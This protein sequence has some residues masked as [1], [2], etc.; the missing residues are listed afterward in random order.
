MRWP[1]LTTRRWLV[2]IAVVG[3]LLS[4]Q[5]L[6]R[7][8]LLCQRRAGFHAAVER[9]ASD[10]ASRIGVLGYCGMA[11]PPR[12]PEQERRTTEERTAWRECALYHKRVSWKYQLAAWCPWMPVPTDAEVPGG[13]IDLS[14][15]PF[16]EVQPGDILYVTVATAGSRQG[17]TDA[18]RVG[19]DERILLPRFGSFYVGGLVPSEVGEK[20]SCRLFG[21]LESDPTTPTANDRDDRVSLLARRF[22]D[23]PKSEP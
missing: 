9:E 11:P 17:S 8:W 14:W 12:D 23:E 3:C 7:R 21:T 18:C 4:P 10:S 19:E 13:S 15:P 16:R 6:Y 5:R 20:I 2:L 1:R 22:R